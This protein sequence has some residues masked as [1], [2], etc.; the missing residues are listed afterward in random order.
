MPFMQ[1]VLSATMP[2]QALADLTVVMQL[3]AEDPVDV[4]LILQ[5]ELSAERLVQL[6]AVLT[7][8]QAREEVHMLPALLRELHLTP[9]GAAREDPLP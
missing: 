1:L 9:R 8:L 6:K 5:G 3:W 4:T 2:T 7:Q